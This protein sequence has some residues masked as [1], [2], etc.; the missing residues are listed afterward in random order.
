MTQTLSKPTRGRPRKS[1]VTLGVKQ[2]ARITSKRA[3]KSVISPNIKSPVL[4]LAII[5]A[6]GAVASYFINKE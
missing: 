2:T 3:I 4:K 5:A 6:L 1:A